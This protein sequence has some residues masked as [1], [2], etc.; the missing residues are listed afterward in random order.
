[1]QNAGQ[2]MQNITGEKFKTID[3][4][5][6]Y[7]F[8]LAGQAVA[9]QMHAHGSSGLQP[10]KVIEMAGQKSKYSCKCITKAAEKGF[11]IVF[12]HP[13]ALWRFTIPGIR[14]NQS[15]LIILKIIFIITCIGFDL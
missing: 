10:Q 9:L 12:P 1:M 15:L 4:N 11:F 14:K 8:T 5:L 7:H 6:N 2:L 13:E 3:G